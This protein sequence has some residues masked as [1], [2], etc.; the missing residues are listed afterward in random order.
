MIVDNIV[1]SQQA[2]MLIMIM[3][4]FVPSLFLAGLVAPVDAS[5]LGNC[6]T[7]DALPATHFIITCRG[8]FLKGLG[9]VA[10]SSP[11]LTLLG[12]GIGS[13]LLS[14]ALFRKWIA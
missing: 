1:K 7:S 2:D 13:L 14:L 10:L 6:L 12:I 11:A 3:V 9:V 5:S 4:L 8:V